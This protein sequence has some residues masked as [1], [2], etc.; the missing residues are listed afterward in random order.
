MI[1]TRPE[2][3]AVV[4][5]AKYPPEGIRGLG[6]VR[7]ADYTLTISMAEYTAR[8][9]QETLVATQVETPEAVANL[10]ELLSVQEVDVFFIGPRDLTISSG[11]GDQVEHPA[12]QDMIVK[13]AGR[14]RAAGKVVGTTAYTHEA[15]LKA[16]E[17][18]FQYIVYSVIPMMA[19]AGREYLKLARGQ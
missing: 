14:I 18:G 10:D 1:N 5:A 6:P 4:A 2:A 13:L 12:V 9:N 8:A 16:K 15:L 7:A 17:R 11:Y 3:E 19:Q